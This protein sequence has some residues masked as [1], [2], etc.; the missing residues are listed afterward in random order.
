MSRLEQ[1][2]VGGRRRRSD[3]PKIIEALE[4]GIV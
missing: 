2:G 3:K 4:E 1:E